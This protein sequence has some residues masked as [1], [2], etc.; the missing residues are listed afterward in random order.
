MTQTLTSAFA[1]VLVSDCLSTYDD[2]T[3]RQQKCYFH[4]FEAIREAQALHP[5]GR[6]DYLDEVM[7]LL[8]TALLLKAL[9]AQ[10]E[11][12]RFGQCVD[13]L[14][15]RAQALL[16]SERV[17]PQEQKVR[18][19]LFKQRDHLFTF[20]REAAVP[21]TNNHAERQLRPAVIARKISCGNK[22]QKGAQAW[23]VLCSLAATCAQRTESFSAFL[24][25]RIVLNRPRPP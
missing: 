12:Q 18:Q 9:Q 1:G 16:L 22:T 15:A 23:Q 13:A 3:D 21:A 7:A 17:Q 6:A 10:A 5:L 11:P 8:R 2:A 25:E 20:L 14:E 24:T 4:H 19:R